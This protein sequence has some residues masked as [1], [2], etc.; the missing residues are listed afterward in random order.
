MNESIFPAEA[1]GLDA[2]PWTEWLEELTPVQ[3][4]DG[5]W[6]KREDLFAPLGFGGINGSKLR[7]L[8]MMMAQRA[9]DSQ[10]VVTGASVRSPQHGMTAAVAA[11]LGM[12][13]IHVVGATKPHTAA[14]HVQPQMAARFGAEFHFTGG[15][16]NSVLQP[17]TASIA[18][19][20]GAAIVPYGITPEPYEHDRFHTLGGW[21]TANLP[22]VHTLIVPTGSCNS[23]LSVLKGLSGPHARPSRLRRVVCVGIGPRKLQMTWERM[24]L[25]GIQEGYRYNAETCLKR[26]PIQRNYLE[27]VYVDAFQEYSYD[28]LVK[29][30]IGDLVLH[31]TYEAK[32]VKYLRQHYPWLLQGDDSCLWLVGGPQSEAAMESHFTHPHFEE[33][34]TWKA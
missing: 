7:G 26:E 6:V 8:I 21:Q 23:L 4:I 3:K 15:A 24:G 20:L 32:V 5:L 16:Y 34:P 19:G 29:Q 11:H 12:K 28:Q 2:T 1:Q 30:Q 13:S 10:T 9:D 27:L 22:D 14:K 25:L 31:P 17:T 18:Q 33:L